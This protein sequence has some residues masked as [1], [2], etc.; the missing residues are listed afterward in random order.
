[1]PA[2]T[3]ELLVHTHDDDPLSPYLGTWL[4]SSAL[5]IEGVVHLILF[6]PA[7]GEPAAGSVEV[8][9]LGTS[10]PLSDIHVDGAACH[11]VA[12]PLTLILRREGP[13]LVVG[14][15]SP[16]LPSLEARCLRR[17]WGTHQAG[18]IPSGAH[19]IDPE[20]LERAVADG[21]LP[22]VDSLTVVQDGS[23][24]LAGSYGKSHAS[25]RSLQS[26]TKS[27]T[28]LLM[29]ALVA[30]GEIDVAAPVAQYLRGQAGSRLVRA[31]KQITL[32]EVLSMS[33]GLEW[34]ETQ[35][36][37][38]DPGNDVVRMNQAADWVGYVLAKEVRSAFP[39]GVFEY[40]TGLTLLA[41]EVI[42]SVTGQPVSEAARELLFEPLGIER[43]HWMTN[44]SGTTH[45]GGGLW[46]T[47][48]D[49][50]KIGWLVADHGRWHGRQVLPEDWVDRCVSPQAR[51]E[52]DST[53]VIPRGCV[54]YGYQWW[55]L[56]T[57]VG[58]DCTVASASALGHG[59]QVLHVLPGLATVV[60]ITA[61][62]WHGVDEIAGQSLK[63]LLGKE[64]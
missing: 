54:A 7:P 38:Q 15:T 13:A 40:Q 35:T 60:A 62:D 52:A 22:W 34:N 32:H 1:M 29:G 48:R 64:R 9:S 16:V 24:L 2:R 46:L 56:S 53:A 11:A 12:G 19:D 42:R 30:R 3:L 31:G 28:S 6:R 47:P 27:V 59:G 50:A 44:E 17:R 26:A 55:L 25:L 63:L 5:P 20:R 33:V 49:F 51:V 14:M 10:I 21:V 18:T 23:V 8:D 39:E 37:Y 43:Y 45:T 41:G 4:G 61:H 57:V 58:E 36:S